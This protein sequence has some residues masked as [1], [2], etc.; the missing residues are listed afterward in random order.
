MSSGPIT[1]TPKRFN[2]YHA[3]IQIEDLKA[4][5][6]PRTAW[7][8]ER[9][10]RCA[11]TGLQLALLLARHCADDDRPEARVE[12]RIERLLT[13]AATQLRLLSRLLGRWPAPPSEL[14][15]RGE[16]PRVSGGAARIAEWLPASH[17][18]ALRTLRDE[19]EYAAAELGFQLDPAP[20]PARH[21]A[22]LDGDAPTPRTA[23]LANDAPAL[24]CAD[25]IDPRLIA[26]IF[27]SEPWS[28]ED[29][30][31]R[32]I[33]QITEC[34]LVVLVDALSAARELARAECWSPA[35]DFVGDVA[36]I[37]DYLAGHLQV[38]D[39][40]VLKDYH[41]VR[42][43]MKG[44]SGAQSQA[45]GSVA[46]L[47][48]GLIEPLCERYPS[49]ERIYQ[50]PH[51]LLE[52]YLY[53]EALTGLEDSVHAF[54][55]NHYRRALHV[56][57]SRGLGAFAQGVEVLPKRFLTA[58]YPELDDVR[59]HLVIESNYEHG[60]IQGTLVYA[61]E[62]A[63]GVPAPQV[64]DQPPPQGDDLRT[65]VE[66]LRQGLEELSTEAV[67]RLFAEDCFV[68]DPV[69][70]RPYRGQG[71]VDGYLRACYQAIPK[72]SYRLGEPVVDGTRVLV[73]WT[74]DAEAFNGASMELAG[75][76]ELT[77]DSDARIRSFVCHWDP[78]TMA[79]ALS[80]PT[81]TLEPL[82]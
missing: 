77:F 24:H 31:F 36:G 29:L 76:W 43:A 10:V 37:L 64:G 16:P 11:Y 48:R 53:A 17:P 34:W 1:A 61:S 57:S 47:A 71:N 58:L 45:A 74:A 54:F 56:Q 12:E 5:W 60:N 68:C 13:G 78:A 70:S 18:R 50:H 73:A 67:L 6:A 2:P 82:I 21:D 30:V 41:P 38:L 25:L 33:H 27:D 14:T 66:V 62:L 23:S 49:L 39:L 3:W 44:A 59:L 9:P 55:F 19:L 4:L 65:I 51:E 72:I 35:A 75:S 20:L 8:G 40:M 42:V 7:V 79:Q 46:P 52:P 22:S 26:A 28:E 63:N 32:T 81:V 69:G 80:S 15:E